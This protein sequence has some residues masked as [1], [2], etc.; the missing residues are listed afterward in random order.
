M[1]AS[2]LAGHDF[3]FGLFV[4]H[5]RI[6][7]FEDL[8]FRQTSVFE[9]RD[10]RAGHDRLAGQVFVKDELHRRIR[11]ADE[12][13]RDG[14]NTDGV[15]LAGVRNIEN[16]FLGEAGPGQV[17][18]RLGADEEDLVEMRGTDK[19]DACIVAD[20][21]MLE[22][23]DLSDFRIRDVQRFQLLNIAGP[24]PRLIQRTKV[25]KGMLVT[26]RRQQDTRTE[27][28]SLVPHCSI[29][30]KAKQEAEAC[31]GVIPG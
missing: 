22:C 16:L 10:F 3:F 21:R 4:G 30:E 6:D 2:P 14:I 7:A 26:T 8:S 31:A 23:D 27:K 20:S 15:Q 18:R 1:I 11:E 24:H 29:L 17:S 5:S 13:E 25:R 19:L 9:L 28:Q 12:L